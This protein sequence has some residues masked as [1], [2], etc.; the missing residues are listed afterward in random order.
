M[1]D[2]VECVEEKKTETD[3]WVKNF[4]GMACAVV[5]FLYKSKRDLHR[6]QWM[7]QLH[8]TC[9]INVVMVTGSVITVIFSKGLILST[10]VT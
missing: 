3:E 9:D 4:R 10:K 8:L 5:L 7:Y 2:C 6:T 1:M